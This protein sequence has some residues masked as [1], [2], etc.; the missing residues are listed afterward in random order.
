MMKTRS[1]AWNGSTARWQAI[2]EMDVLDR[3]RQQLAREC[4][5]A[6]Y[7]KDIDLELRHGVLTVRGKVPTYTLRSL[8]ETILA[9]VEGVEQIDN[10]VG[11]V[12]STGLSS[13]CSK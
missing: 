10:Q 6:Y 1:R 3:A 13:V 11:V 4:P 9:D 12:S 8:L 5:S 7:F 2:G